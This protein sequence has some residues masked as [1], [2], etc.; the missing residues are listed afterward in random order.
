[1]SFSAKIFAVYWAGAVLLLIFLFR[2]W[3]GW[4]LRSVV[5]SLIARPREQREPVRLIPE[6]LY[7]VQLS[8]A[9]VSCAR[10]DGTIES[11]EWSDL[12]KVELLT[13][14]EGLF[15]PDVFWI[16]C[17]SSSGCVVPQGATGEQQLMDQMG[18]LPGFNWKP[19]I[20]GMKTTRNQRFLCWSKNNEP[21]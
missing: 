8:E 14:D 13:T 20:E 12:C 21:A 3:A 19:V 18:K 15:A 10:P 7:K 16:L 2:R 17:G 5:K 1:M 6:S 11:V 9:G 4:R